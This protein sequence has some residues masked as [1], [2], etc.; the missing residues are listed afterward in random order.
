MKTKLTLLII[1]VF[2]LN[3]CSPKDDIIIKDQTRLAGGIGTSPT[4][5]ALLF[6]FEIPNYYSFA[7]VKITLHGDNETV[8]NVAGSGYREVRFSN[9][10]PGVHDYTFEFWTYGSNTGVSADFSFVNGNLINTNTN[11]V[12]DYTQQLTKSESIN[13]TIETN[14]NETLKINIKLN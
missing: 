6:S 2:T 3:S 13:E 11:S 8:R 7:F 9:V 14:V 12:V 1:L 10:K 4:Q 5:G